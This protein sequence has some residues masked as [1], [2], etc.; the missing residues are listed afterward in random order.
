MHRS[1]LAAL[2]LAPLAFGVGGAVQA[3]SIITDWDFGTLATNAKANYDPAVATTGTGSASSLGMTNSYVYTNGA[4]GATLGTGSVTDDDIVNDSVNSGGAG[5]NG[6]T[7]GNGNVWR[8][9]GVAGTGTTGTANNGWNISAPQYSQGAEFDTSTVGYNVTQ[10]SFNWAA[11][12]Q[13]VGNLQV[14]YNTN[15]NNAGGWTNVGSVWSATV[16]NNATGSA[17]SGFAT[18]T[19]SLAGIA[20][21]SNDANF[22]IRLVSAYNPTLG[23]YAAA[24]SV[25]SGTP[26]ELNNN[27]G[28]WRIADVQIDGSAVPLPASVWMLLSGVFGVSLLA[29][30][31]KLTVAGRLGAA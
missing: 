9:R 14:Q 4:G 31:N 11:T 22:G 21:L 5:T 1:R 7:L 2:T 18:D 30:R 17:G 10:L 26:T 20:G 19:V 6:S 13:G 27:S 3:A 15:I 29:K 23:L 25:V 8:I 16:D 28:N 24:G 12:T